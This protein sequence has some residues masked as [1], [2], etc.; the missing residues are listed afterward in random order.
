MKTT[1]F[2]CLLLILFSCS[3]E[4]KNDSNATNDSLTTSNDTS[5]INIK[6]EL[7]AISTEKWLSS[8]FIFNESNISMLLPENATFYDLNAGEYKKSGNDI[9]VDEK[10]KI[11]LK[12]DYDVDIETSS[13]PVNVEKIY[14]DRLAWGEKSGNQKD[15]KLVKKDTNFI[16][17][18]AVDSYKSVPFYSIIIAKKAGNSFLFTDSEQVHYEEEET[19]T[20]SYKNCWEIVK[21][22]ESITKK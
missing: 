15:F 1:A 6:N 20:L 22:Y 14:N 11:I 9:E 2:Y 4:V 12:N 3:T 5:T 19:I 13:S 8:S 16:I 10:L 18:S 17:Y 7:D 21:M